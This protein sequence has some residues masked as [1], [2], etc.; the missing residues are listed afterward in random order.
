MN[1]WVIYRLARGGHWSY[2]QDVLNFPL[3][4]ARRTMAD[5]KLTQLLEQLHTELSTAEAV[6]EKGRD[7]LRALN[8]DIEALLERSEGDDSS[9]S[10][11]ERLQDSIEHFEV[12]HPTLTSALAQ[13]LNAL[14]NAGI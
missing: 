9:D 10:L 3:Q 5:Q 13:M 2:N 8:T 1:A 14:N 4:K 6:D 11:L 7:L 12:S